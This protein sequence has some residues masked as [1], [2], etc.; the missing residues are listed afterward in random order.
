M[1]RR[2][3]VLPHPEGPG[4]DFKG[5]VVDGGRIPEPLRHPLEENGGLGS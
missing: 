3:V 5:D 1:I 2:S 4:T